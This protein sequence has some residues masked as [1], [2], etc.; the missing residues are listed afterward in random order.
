MKLRPLLLSRRCAAASLLLAVTCVA[1]GS[2]AQ[3]SVTRD[4]EPIGSALISADDY[5]DAARRANEEGRTV[6]EYEIDAAGRV[7]PGSCRVT[8]SSGHVRLD[9]KTCTIIE[10]RYRFKP[11]LRNGV[12]VKSSHGQTI[13]WKIPGKGPSKAEQ[14]NVAIHIVHNHALCLLSGD[15]TLVRRI[16][17]MPLSSSEQDKA[18]AR[19]DE[20]KMKCRGF[21]APVRFPPL[22]LVGALAERVIKQRLSGETELRLTQ[23]GTGPVPRNGTEGVAKCV[24]RRNFATASALLATGPAK[25]DEAAMVRELVPDIQACIPAG[26]TLRLNQISVRSL[27]AVGLYRETITP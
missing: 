24:V 5:P 26:L 7:V 23:E 10:T 13:T 11:A 9:Q 22:M 3:S 1:S 19:V 18:I 21:D 6:V 14:T 2:R 25:R 20:D 17:D 8:S 4:A 12:P 27:V 15:P 16:L